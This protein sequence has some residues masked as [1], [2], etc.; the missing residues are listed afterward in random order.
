M[1]TALVIKVLKTIIYDVLSTPVSY[2][3]LD[4]YKRQELSH[5]GARLAFEEQ[6]LIYMG[7]T[8]PSDYLYICRNLTDSSGIQTRP[9]SVITRLERIFGDIETEEFNPYSVKAVDRPIPVLHRIG[10]KLAEGGDMDVLWNGAYK[11][12]EN[13][14]EYSSCLLYTSICLQDYLCT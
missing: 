14:S 3:H 7:I 9:S 4:V 12:L 1:D 6:Y 5:S 11:W 8:K 10:E 13:N 2:P